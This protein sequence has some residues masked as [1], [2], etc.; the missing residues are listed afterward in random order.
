MKGD[1]LHKEL[2]HTLKAELKAEVRFDK[3]SRVLYSTDASNFQ[4]EPIGVV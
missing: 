2:E 1:S 4:I 3:L